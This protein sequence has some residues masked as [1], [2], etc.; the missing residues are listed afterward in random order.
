MERSDPVADI[1][2]RIM[3]MMDR[4]GAS[5]LS[6]AG[7]FRSSLARVEASPVRPAGRGYE[8]RRDAQPDRHL[9]PRRLRAAESD[10]SSQVVH[11]ASLSAQAQSY[12]VE[13]SL[14]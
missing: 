5:L 3:K 8:R 2:A 10:R 12:V 7:P 9:S 1:L 14:Q 4:S 6:S 11:D 13:R